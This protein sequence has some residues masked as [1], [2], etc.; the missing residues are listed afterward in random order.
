MSS[1]KINLINNLS[2]YQKLGINTFRIE[3]FD[4]DNQTIKKLINELKK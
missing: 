1:T 4:E 2:K 3:L